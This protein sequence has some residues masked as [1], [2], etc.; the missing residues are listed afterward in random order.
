MLLNGK[1]LGNLSAIEAIPNQAIIG[2]QASQKAALGDKIA[3]EIIWNAG[4]R[5]GIDRPTARS[6]G[7]AG[8]RA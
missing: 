8:P 1:R 6:S 7:C 2:F 5:D 4:A 3:G